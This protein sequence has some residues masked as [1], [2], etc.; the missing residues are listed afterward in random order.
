MQMRLYKRGYDRFVGVRLLRATEKSLQD[1]AIC[2][3]PLSGSSPDPAPP[4]RN[5]DEYIESTEA[6]LAASRGGILE[7]VRTTTATLLSW[8]RGVGRR[9]RRLRA[10][11]GVALVAI[12]HVR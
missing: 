9:S 7:R 6:G 10:P 8:L 1:K 4:S 12:E 3:P 5:L 11:G 2:P